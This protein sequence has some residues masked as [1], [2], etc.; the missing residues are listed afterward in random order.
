MGYVRLELESLADVLPLDGVQQNGVGVQARSG[1]TGLGLPPVQVQWLEGAGD[2]A[3]A[4]GWRTLP[5]DID[6]PL[7]IV[8]AD[9]E[10]L[11]SWLSKLARVLGKPSMTPGT[12]ASTLYL[13]F[14]DEEGTKWSCPVEHVGGGD[15]TYGTDTIGET[16]VELVVTLRAGDPYWSDGALESWTLEELTAP[17]SGGSTDSSLPT[18]AAYVSYASLFVAGDTFKAVLNKVPAGKILTLPAGTYTFSDFVD[19]GL[20]GLFI[21]SN[22]GG[23]IGVGRNTILQMTASSSTKTTKNNGECHLIGVMHSNFLLR[24]VQIKGT[25]QGHY[26]SGLQVGNGSVRYQT[27]VLI[28]GVYFNRANPG[29]QSWGS[30]G[31]TFGLEAYYTNGLSITNCEF[32]GRNSTGANDTGAP[33]VIRGSVNSFLSDVYAHHAKAGACTWYESSDIYTNNLRSEF[34]GTTRDPTSGSAILHNNCG[35]NITHE[36]ATLKANYQGLTGGNTG[37]HMEFWSYKANAN[38]TVNGVTHDPGPGKGGC[39]AV[40]IFDRPGGRPN[41]QSTDLTIIKDGIT[42]QR[43]DANTQDPDRG[44]PAR[45]WYRYH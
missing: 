38:V 13:N 36:N 1:T 11:I 23:I 9:R 14:Y 25:D 8:G 45:D 5:R 42:L 26:Y 29:S 39:F 30:T 4:H 37:L 22:V 24:N 2:G 44:N 41:T 35:G 34:N 21:P 20:Y 27:G 18:G 32:E 33:F 7:D 40:Y 15:Y 6:L 28:D 43:K 12:H 19:N 31:V 17:P 10:D 3:V 16:D